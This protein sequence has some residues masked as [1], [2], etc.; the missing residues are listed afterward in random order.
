M[1]RRRSKVR[2]DAIDALRKIV[3][4]KSPLMI[5]PSL[6]AQEVLRN[7]CT[8]GAITLDPTHTTMLLDDPQRESLRKA[9]AA[10]AYTMVGRIPFRTQRIPSQGMVVM[11]DRDP[12]LRRPFMVAVADPKRLPGVRLDAARAFAAY[13]RA[14]ATQQ[15]IG[16]YGR[17]LVDADPLFFPVIVHGSH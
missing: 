8:A 12:M 13:L 7:I 5:A 9:A 15:W 14:P 17:G 10:G 4:A 2:T 3:A 11:V 1:T 16:N 6:G